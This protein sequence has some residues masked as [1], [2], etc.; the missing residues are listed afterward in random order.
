MLHLFFSML[1][2]PLRS[3]LYVPCADL[4][5][6]YISKINFLAHVMIVKWTRVEGKRKTVF[7]IKT[8][9]KCEP[10]SQ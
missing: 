3:P 7:L 10:F 5:Q 4:I 9:T 6:E 1:S 8:T 2:F